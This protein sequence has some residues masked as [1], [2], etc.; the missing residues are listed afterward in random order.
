M[1][2]KEAVSKALAQAASAS[3]VELA[4]NPAAA[5]GKCVITTAGGYTECKDNMTKDG[6]EKQG[7]SGFSAVW[8]EGGKC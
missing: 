8:T 4:N 6:C 1:S 2:D 3:Q 5:T 7:G